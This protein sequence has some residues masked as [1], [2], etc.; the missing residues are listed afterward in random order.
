ML[1]KTPG[2]I[3]L[4]DNPTRNECARR[5]TRFP[6]LQIGPQRRRYDLY[7]L[8]EAHR[9]IRLAPPMRRAIQGRGLLLVVVVVDGEQ[10]VVGRRGCG[11]GRRS[12]RREVL[13]RADEEGLAIDLVVD[14][15]VLA[16]TPAWHEMITWIIVFTKEVRG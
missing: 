5:R 1:R 15:T 2:R 3:A 14:P 12:L 4:I 8:V 6:A 11:R 7:V 13:A 10:D 16:A 9:L